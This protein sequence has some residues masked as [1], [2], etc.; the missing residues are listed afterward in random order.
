MEEQKQI[1]ARF[2]SGAVFKGSTDDF[3]PHRPVFHLR[4]NKNTV[5]PVK[6]S[7]LKAVFFVKNHMGNRS[8]RK[9]RQFPKS[10]LESE[11]GKRVAVL[12]KD[13]EL[14]IGYTLSYTPGRKGFFMSPVDPAGNNVRIYVLTHATKEV[15]TGSEAELLVQSITGESKRRKAA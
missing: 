11:A 14:L 12:F 1:V 10:P 4:L 3:S 8:Y 9:V 5:K 15:K 2:T 7:D 13:A 6:M